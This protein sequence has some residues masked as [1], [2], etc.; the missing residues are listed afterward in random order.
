MTSP[1]Q[2]EEA[3]AGGRLTIDLAA[4]QANWRAMR[5]ASGD[6]ATAAVVKS[7]GYGLGIEPVA[8][9]LQAAGCGTFFVALPDE[10]RRVREAIGEAEIFVLAGLTGD[11]ARAYRHAGLA[12]V[13]NSSNDVAVWARLA[14][15]AETPLPCALHIDTGMNRLGLT[16]AEADD[17]AA[18]AAALAALAPTLVMSHL[19]CADEPDHPL[20]GEQLARF[21]AAA[22]QFPGVRRSLANSAGVF[23]GADF[24]FDLTRPGIALYGGE[25]VVGMP[26][27]TQPVAT[28][29]GRI[30]Q[31]R[32]AKRAESVGYGATHVLDRD[33]R[34][35]VVGVGYGDGYPRAASGS[36]V[37]MS[38]AGSGAVGAIGGHRAPVLG[39]VS[40]DLTA[41]DV[42]DVP[43]PVLEKAEWVE[44]IGRTIPVDEAARAAG[45]IGYEL[46]THLG[47]RYVRHYVGDTKNGN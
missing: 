25:C 2:V 27:H 37:P 13:L 8:R 1:S 19:A 18:D 7:D 34:I 47:R 43:E 12:P 33:S 41:F 44:L 15:E 4:L 28:L 38:T 21:K 5:E 30:L 31:V 46:L 26:A 42:T 11:N 6:A 10:G 29:E 24:H 39:R 35:A 9:A 3:L 16:P 40:M 36:G 20:N 23:L 14:R 45:T 17:L 32:E 22:R